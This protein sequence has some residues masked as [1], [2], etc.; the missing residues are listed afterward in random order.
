MPG[1][2]AF[3]AWAFRRLYEYVEYKATEFGRYPHR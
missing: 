3:H 1:A 2:K